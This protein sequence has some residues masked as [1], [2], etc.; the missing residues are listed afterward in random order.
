MKMV[1]PTFLARLVLVCVQDVPDGDIG[2]HLQ[3][4]VLQAPSIVMF[5]NDKKSHWRVHS[6]G[7]SAH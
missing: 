1:V 4:G 7:W 2:K 6:R 3:S 5:E